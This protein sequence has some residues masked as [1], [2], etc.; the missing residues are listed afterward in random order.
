MKFTYHCHFCGSACEPVSIL[1]Y[2]R[3]GAAGLCRKRLCSVSCLRVW[4]GPG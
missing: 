4:L 3:K 2:I 1:V